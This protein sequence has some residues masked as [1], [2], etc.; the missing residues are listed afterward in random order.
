[1]NMW[2]DE[3]LYDGNDI[4]LV[5]NNENSKYMKTDHDGEKEGKR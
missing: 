4:G 5:E 1:M 2:N 3:L